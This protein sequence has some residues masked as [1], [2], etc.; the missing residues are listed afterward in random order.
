[1]TQEITEE[2]QP[3]V[4]PLI[5]MSAEA[6][7]IAYD[8]ATSNG[9]Q[10]ESTAD[11]RT[12]TLWWAPDD[13][14]PETDTV[15]VTLHGHA[16]WATNAFT[17]WHTELQ[18]R[19]FAFL[20]LQWWMGESLEVNGYIKHDEL[21]GYLL[22]GLEAHNIEPGRIIFE[23]FSM[24]SA[25]TFIVS[26]QDQQKEEPYFNVIIAN[27]GVLEL[28]EPYNASIAHGD[29]GEQPYEGTHWILYCGMLDEE[30]ENW[31]KQMEATEEWLKRMGATIDL[32]IEDPTGKHSGMMAPQNKEKVMDTAESLL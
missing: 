4:S 18:K 32:F 29:Y 28:S 24:G 20:S 9:V 16:A 23:G 6:D 1:M 11:G 19:H 3:L 14:N 26:A 13:F 5:E 25:A 22:E 31:C 30:H 27:S 12:F 17:A 10:L 8:Y 7:P 2:T 15:L 21:Y